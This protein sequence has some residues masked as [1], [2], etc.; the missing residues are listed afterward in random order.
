M[1]T[2][3]NIL[4]TPLVELTGETDPGLV[5]NQMES[6]EIRQLQSYT[7]QRDNYSVSFIMTRRQFAIFKYFHSRIL[8][9]GAAKFALPLPEQRT[10][11]MG[12]L[13]GVIPGGNYS[14]TAIAGA[15]KWRVE[16]PFS[17]QGD[18]IVNQ[19]EYELLQLSSI[20]T[21]EDLNEAFP[22]DWEYNNQ[23]EN[24]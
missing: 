3:P 13:E 5:V 4:P 12:S 1:I 11:A 14:F 21:I 20:D 8:G 7:T 2:W 10:L 17:H 23:H 6:G 24:T 22:K 18:D 15:E 16:F 9:G 19:D